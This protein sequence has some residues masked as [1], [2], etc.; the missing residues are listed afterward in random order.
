MAEY[1][2][3]INTE[4]QLS[5][6]EMYLGEIQSEHFLVET[7]T[8]M[9]LSH[10]QRAGALLIKVKE[11]LAHGSFIYWIESNCSFSLR[12]AQLYM[13]LYNN[14]ELIGKAQELAQLSAGALTI[15]KAVEIIT[16]G[17]RKDRYERNKG[18]EVV[19][20]WSM[21]T[22]TSELAEDYLKT[23]RK[24][25]ESLESAREAY[26]IGLYSSGAREATIRKNREL[27]ELIEGFN[28]LLQEENNNE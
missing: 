18:K 19:S 6:A 16:E 4:K 28:L 24:I 14:R 25:K 15:S 26:R 13:N 12:T 2:E 1:L 9:A 20:T 10:A 3:R 8:R 5:Q 23:I 17:K 11:A 7:H 27:I 22:Y 21:K